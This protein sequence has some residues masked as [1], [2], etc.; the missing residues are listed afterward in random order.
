MKV[1][2]IGPIYPYRGGV[3]HSNRI[4]CE[5]LAKNHDVTAISFTRMYP[6]FLYPGK[7][8]KETKAD[9][10]FGVRTQYMLD[11]LNPFSWL[12][13][14][15]KIKKEQPEW[16][17]FR[18]WHTIFTP[19]YWTIVT[20]GRNP[21]TKFSAVCGNIIQH[22]SSGLHNLLNG[23]LHNPLQS[24]FLGSLD[25]LITF[26]KS[27][28]HEVHRLFPGKPAA[29]ITEST[30]E[31]QFGKMPSQKEARKQLKVSGDA[32]MFFGFIRPYKG[33]KFLLQAMPR[34]LEEKPN[35]TLMIVGEF[36]NDKQDYLDLIKEHHLESRVLIVDKYVSNAEVPTYFAAS[37]AIVLPY[38]SSSESGI[39]Q[40]AYGLNTPV[41]T[42]AVGG[43]VDL[44][45]HGKTGMLC[46][47]EN[48]ADLARVVI[49]FYDKELSAPIRK[50]M[51][52]NADLFKWTP[53]KEA[54]FFNQPHVT[55]KEKG[56]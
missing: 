31:T 46:K 45:E 28:L 36:W 44:I 8:Q 53:T 19:M 54:V 14:A 40:L 15:R 5:N 26:S 18:W 34:I 7:E 21:K 23:L 43:N 32:I 39:I 10:S 3:A 25:Y 17:T 30:Y 4:Q 24:L 41:I 52:L 50:G 22:E 35:L 20:F 42:T 29:W 27:D 37:D 56:H 1:F 55:K 12:A 47:S 38:V 51:K 33:L 2:C 9:P 16:V 11:F 13:V 48:P 6:S 49:E